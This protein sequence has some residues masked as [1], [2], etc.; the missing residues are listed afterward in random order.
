MTFNIWDT[1]FISHQDCT[2]TLHLLRFMCQTKWFRSLTRA[3]I[4]GRWTQSLAL[5]SRRHVLIEVKS[6]VVSPVCNTN[7]S[8]IKG[9]RCLYSCHKSWGLQTV[10][11]NIYCRSY[12]RHSR[13]F[14]EFSIRHERRCHGTNFFPCL[15]INTVTLTTPARSPSSLAHFLVTNYRVLV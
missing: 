2:Q 1:Q 3:R 9:R 15:Y 8:V 4:K 14:S 11:W 5:L 12:Y 13:W 6:T 10:G 7:Y